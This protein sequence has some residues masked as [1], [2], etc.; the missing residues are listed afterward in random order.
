MRIPILVSSVVAALAGAGV[1]ATAAAAPIS[2]VPGL[3]PWAATRDLGPAGEQ[4]HVVLTLKSHDQPGLDRF[5]AD[6]RHPSLSSAEYQARFGPAPSAEQTTEAWLAGTGLDVRHRPGSQVFSLRGPATRVGMAFGTELHRLA[7]PGGTTVGAIRAG[8]LPAPVAEV[9]AGVAGLAGAAHARTPARASRANSPADVHPMGPQ[10]FASF[11]SVP[12][13]PSG[14][15]QRVAVV[16]WTNMDGVVSDLAQFQQAH[17]LPQV[18]MTVDYVDG[19]PTAVNDQM[20]WDLDTQYATAMAPGLDEV[21]V[22]ASRSSE[23]TDLTV[24]F[25]KW[26]DENAYPVASASLGDCETDAKDWVGA[27]EPVLQKAEAQGQTLLAASGDD[28]TGCF[29]GVPDQR[30]YPGSSP[31]AVAVGGTEI[32]DI[33]G[34]QVTGWSGSGGGES[35][36]L[37]KPAW[38]TAPIPHGTG[39]RALP[40]LSFA[41]TNY[42]IV[43]NGGSNTVAGTSA[44][45]PVIAAFL[46][47]ARETNP[48]IGFLGQRLYSLGESAYT[49]I[50]SGNNGEPAGPGWDYVTGLGEPAVTAWLAAVAR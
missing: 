14:R 12:A 42:S 49:D 30:S 24:A 22:Y 11:Y 13:E 3:A 46:A 44:S 6:P 29:N 38:Q 39:K 28:G 8:A 7:G 50:T 40:D 32:T 43:D 27:L 23:N 35:A 20:E 26:A 17:K 4:Q 16:G 2:D 1:T 19:K 15:G 31:H 21:H 9:T 25:S 5:L 37:A 36:A 41:A 34:H 33:S 45:T 48:K 10:D 18:P 47:R